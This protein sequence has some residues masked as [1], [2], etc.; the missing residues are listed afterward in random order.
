MRIQILLLIKVMI[1]YHRSPDSPGLHFIS[2]R[3]SCQRSWLYFEPPKLL[4]FD[5]DADPD[6]AF[7][8]NANPKPASKNNADP[9][10]QRG[11]KEKLVTYIYLLCRIQLLIKLSELEQRLMS[12]CSDKIQLGSFVSAFQVSLPSGR[13]PVFWMRI[14]I[15]SD[16]EVGSSSWRNPSILRHSG[17]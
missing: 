9:D 8:S 11:L 6:P 17:I 10:S 13:E 7:H 12:G 2:P 16:P 5:F 14:L 15:W 4:N 3:F 1:Y